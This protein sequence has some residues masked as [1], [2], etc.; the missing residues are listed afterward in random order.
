M[1][2]P[3]V[4]GKSS[5]LAFLAPLLEP[6]STTSSA[7]LTPI[8]SALGMTVPAFIPFC[9]DGRRGATPKVVFFRRNRFE[10]SGIYARPVLAK[11]VQMESGRDFSDEEFVAKNVGSLCGCSFAT[12]GPVRNYPVAIA[13]DVASP[14]PTPATFR[15]W[16]NVFPEALQQSRWTPS[17]LSAVSV[18]RA[19]FS[20]HTNG[21][22]PQ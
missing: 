11:V 16:C 15:H 18:P 3:L 22:S 17:E 12:L 1:A 21:G 7:A 14:F 13:A 20:G 8:V 6:C 4:V 5:R 2:T 9:L 10:M 19:V